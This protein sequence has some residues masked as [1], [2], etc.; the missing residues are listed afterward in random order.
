MKNKRIRAIATAGVATIAAM[1]AFG[2]TAAQAAPQ[3]FGNID[4]D[5]AGSLT[6][7]K[8]LH[9]SGTTEGDISEAPAPGD[10]TDPVADVEF[11]AYPLVKE[12]ES[13]PLDLTVAANWDLLSTLTAGPSCT[14]PAGF[15][16]GSPVVLPL[17]DAAG[18]ATTPLDLGAYQIC[19]TDA[20]ANIVDTAA[21]FI[22]T[23]PMPHADGWVYD[24]HA[25]PKNG[26]TTIEK[27]VVAQEGLGLGA[28]VQFPVTTP[29][30]SMKGEAWTAYSISD[31]FDSRLSPNP[32]TDGIAS[33]KV[34]GVDLDP[35]YYTKIVDG[36]TV[37]ME[38]TAAGIAWLN[39]SPDQTGKVIEVVFDSVIN[40]VGD[41]TL[42]NDAQLWVNNPER[43]SSTKPSVPSNEVR[44]HWGSLAIL[45][46]AAGTSGTEGTLAGAVF[47]VYNAE[48]PYA[49]D[50]STAVATGNPIEVGGATQFTSDA[51]GVI[52]ITGLFV[53]DSDNPAIDADQR[54]YVLKEV[55]APSGY[56][57]PAG[58]A[59]F[60]GVGIKTGETTT[61]DNGA[62][63][64][65]QQNVPNLPLTGGSGTGLLVGLGV[66]GVSIA[67][68]LAMLKR[69]REKTIDAAA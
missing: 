57:L 9:Q 52:S 39:Q 49:T 18:T 50:C 30:P 32:A 48:D 44:T 45:K 5:R 27:T 58:D 31:T 17:T 69:R 20:P 47:E 4:A 13:A 23:V 16:L 33:V 46:R 63:E 55:E 64:N 53:S 51:D 43:D 38:F 36:Q 42:L 40:E 10:F 22:L 12:G 21:P 67:G 35:S 11:T 15:T 56:V 60:T 3:D 24:V 19:E 14:A 65:S 34:D 61:A 28:P 26:A 62:I 41:G 8:F 68:G 1:S 25:Y 7:H 37:V 29:V 59:A 2:V 54:C 6:V 66:A